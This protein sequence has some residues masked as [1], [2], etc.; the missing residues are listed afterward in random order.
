MRGVSATR[1]EHLINRR[2]IFIA[3]GAVFAAAPVAVK[4]APASGEKKRHRVAIHVD[5]NDP[6]VMNLAINNSMNI[7]EYYQQRGEPV[8]I[9]IVANSQGL[10]MFRDDTSPVK[11]KIAELRAKIPGTTFSAC[12]NTKGN[13]EKSEG[14][15]VPILSQARVVPSGAVRLIELQEQHFSYVK[16]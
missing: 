4:A 14:K 3:L 8:Q 5:Q 1:G 10:N 9:E 13:M 12:G 15:P 6:A 11:D 2:N 16:P 7:Y